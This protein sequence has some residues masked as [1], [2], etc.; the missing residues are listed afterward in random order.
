[1]EACSIVMCLP[2]TPTHSE[3]AIPIEQRAYDCISRPRD[4]RPG[5]DDFLLS[6]P[7][8][9]T[10]SSNPFMNLPSSPRAVHDQQSAKNKSLPFGQYSALSARFGLRIG[11][12]DIGTWYKVH[13]MVQKLLLLKHPASMRVRHARH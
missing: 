13:A 6:G 10:K 1:M 3:Q 9:V 5:P 2:W 8:T 11:A 7:R 4:L 12:V